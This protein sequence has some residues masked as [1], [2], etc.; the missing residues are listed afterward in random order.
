MLSSHFLFDFLELDSDILAAEGDFLKDGD[1]CLEGGISLISHPTL[2]LDAVGVVL[3]E[4]ERCVVDDDGPGEIPA[5]LVEVLQ[6]DLVFLLSVL[7][8]EAVA[9]SFLLVDQ[10]QYPSRGKKNSAYQLAY[11]SWPAVN[12]TSS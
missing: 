1:E 8:K 10:L 2:D 4:V 12:R 5:Q 7:S 9:D 3:A 6:V 11:P